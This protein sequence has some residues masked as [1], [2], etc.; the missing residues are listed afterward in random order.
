MSMCQQSQI[1][2]TKVYTFTSKGCT[3]QQKQHMTVIQGVGN[4]THHYMSSDAVGKT[5]DPSEINKSQDVALGYVYLSSGC[6][7]QA[8]DNHTCSGYCSQEFQVHVITKHML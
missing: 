4:I 8:N 1:M 6:V 3:D 7:Q 5:A 2:S